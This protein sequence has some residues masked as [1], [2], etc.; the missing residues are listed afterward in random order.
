MNN[1]SLLQREY[2][3]L[4]NRNSPEIGKSYNIFENIEQKYDDNTGEVLSYATAPSTYLGKCLNVEIDC[5]GSKIYYDCEFEHELTG[6]I[7]HKCFKYEPFI[8]EVPCLHQK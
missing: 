7:I 6:E 2:K 5:M 8:I 4:I 3:Q 1:S